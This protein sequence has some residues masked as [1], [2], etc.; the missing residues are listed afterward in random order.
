MGPG[1]ESE[2]S[3]LGLNPE[4]V[5]HFQGLPD[6]LDDEQTL[7]P[8]A[9]STFPKSISN[10]HD[11]FLDE[12]ENSAAFALQDTYLEESLSDSSSSKRTSSGASS[13]GGAGERDAQN[14]VTMDDGTFNS[15][16]SPDQTMGTPSLQSLAFG[17][18][19]FDGENSFDEDAFLN[20]SFDFDRASSSPTD[21]PKVQAAVNRR[22]AQ[23]A[24]SHIKTKSVRYP[25][26]GYCITCSNSNKQ[27][28]FRRPSRE[29]SPQSTSFVTSNASSPNGQMDFHPQMD[30]AQFLLQAQG[31]PQ[32]LRGAANPMPHTF[33]NGPTTMAASNAMMLAHSNLMPIPYGMN[34]TA[35]FLSF[36]TEGL[37]PRTRVETQ[38]HLKTVFGQLP[39]GVAKLRLPK[40]TISKPKLWSKEPSA[41]SPDTLELHTMLVCTSAMENEESRKRAFKRA[42]EGPN[43]GYGDPRPEEETD[44]E[45]PSKGGEVWICNNCIDRERKRSERKK[46]KKPEE[47]AL[48][49]GDEWRRVVVFNTHELKEFPKPDPLT[50]CTV[51]ELPMRVACYCRHQQEKS[52]FQV[53][54]TI[55]HMGRVICQEL[56]PSIMITD[57]HKN[58]VA[59]QSSNGSATKS[60]ATTKS[61]T[62]AASAPQAKPNPAAQ[63]TTFRTSQP[64]PDPSRL[65]AVQSPASRRLH[66]PEASATSLPL[67]RPA[68]P[69]SLPGPHAKKRK[70]SAGK[71]PVS[72]AMTPLDTTATASPPSQLQSA[73]ASPF[74]SGTIPFNPQGAFFTG[75]SPSAGGSLL[76]T[77]PSTPGMEDQSFFSPR[78]AANAHAE[79]TLARQRFSASRSAH[80]AHASRAPS[81]SGFNNPLSASVLQSLF[82][83]GTAANLAALTPTGDNLAQTP[84][85]SFPTITRIIPPHGSKM[86]GYEVT[87][88]GEGFHRALEVMFG[89][90]KASGT[91]FWGPNILVCVVP[92]SPVPGEVTVTF[93]KHQSGMQCMIN[94]QKFT[95]V[96]DEEDKLLRSALEVLARKMNGNLSDVKDFAMSILN[97]RGLPPH[98]TGANGGAPSGHNYGNSASS[99]SPPMDLE[100]QLMKCLEMIDLDDSPYKAQWDYRDPSGHS[101][102]HLACSRGFHRFAAGL[103]ARG[104]NVDVRDNN[105]FTPIHFAAM[106]D[107][108]EIVRRLLLGGADPALRSQLGL[109]AADVAQS[110]DVIGDLRRAARRTRSRSLGSLRSAPSSSTSLKSLWG[111]VARAATHDGVRDDSDIEYSSFDT[112]DSDDRVQ[113]AEEEDIL[114]MRRPSV[115]PA[116]AD[117]HAAPGVGGQD[118]EM[119]TPPSPNAAAAAFRNFQQ[120]M[121]VYM[122]NLP[123]MP[124]MPQMPALPGMGVQAD[125]APLYYA[126]LMRRLTALVP[127]VLGQ[128]PVTPETAPPSYEDLYPDREARQGDTKPKSAEEARAMQPRDVKGAATAEAEAED[129]A[130]ETAEA[131][132]AGAKV[133]EL[134]VLKIGRKNAI[135]KEQQRDILRAHE[136]KF[137]RLSS[138][139]NLFMIWVSFEPSA[140]CWGVWLTWCRFRCL[141]SCCAPCCTDSSRR[142]SAMRAASCRRF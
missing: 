62:P 91:W 85:Q 29:V 24:K 47:E 52:G 107:N 114:E 128:R 104:A 80:S 4:D 127:G 18:P 131:E 15:T 7:D 48:W 3:F 43:S 53:I 14:D 50:G 23:P 106:N 27:M 103:I 126:Q 121:G 58:H 118:V 86:G 70:S 87:I 141:S 74:A 66:N 82:P 112:S 42:L 35:P 51:V 135:T 108:P 45:K 76:G 2:F 142:C 60:S 81:P 20:Q 64:M 77:A 69:N 30:Q 25:R 96:D 10:S 98:Q 119:E 32:Q 133:D 116:G 79:Q 31:W 129:E 92:S 21:K 39:P 12:Q 105:G 83:A 59:P 102:L 44:A 41:G 111:E 37:P 40:H 56:T 38:I 90:N 61:Q 89:D 117:G 8:S 120:A 65:Q 13:K 73:S 63:P 75:G 36:D 54:F 140:S 68:S 17:T 5:F 95:Y 125:Q 1:E 22:P 109:T 71:L 11:G 16:V 46:V 139:R 6:S 101:M 72:M 138:D 123:Q 137:K 136:A 132:E 57:D 93:P 19:S 34:T 33:A 97:Y 88:L 78:A 130:T 55:R 49:K 9:L 100:S 113:E 124:Q 115:H 67:S 28:S 26:R 84:S 122:Q 94:P 134:G 99:S 110:D